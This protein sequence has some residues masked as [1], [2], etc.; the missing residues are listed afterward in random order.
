[1]RSRPR[2]LRG[3]RPILRSRRAHSTPRSL[4]IGLL[5]VLLGAQPAS[6]QDSGFSTAR[7]D[8]LAAV[9]AAAPHG[10]DD[11]TAASRTL[12]ALIEGGVGSEALAH[13]KVYLEADVDSDLEGQSRRDALASAHQA[14]ARQGDTLRPARIEEVLNAYFVLQLWS[15]DHDTAIVEEELPQVQLVGAGSPNRE[16]VQDTM[17]GTPDREATSAAFDNLLARW[18]AADVGSAE[19]QRAGQA[20]RDLVRTTVGTRALDAFAEYLEA[21][22]GTPAESDARA[23]A[24]AAIPASLTPRRAVELMSAYHFVGLFSEMVE[25]PLLPQTSMPARPVRPGGAAAG[26]TVD[27]IRRAGLLPP[28]SWNRA[29]PAPTVSQVA[30]PDP[31]SGLVVFRLARGQRVRTSGSG[32]FRGRIVNNTGA[33]ILVRPDLAL[34]VPP[35]LGMRPYTIMVEGSL[36]TREEE[37]ECGVTQAGPVK[38]IPVPAGGSVP[39]E[40]RLDPPD[41]AALGFAERWGHL[42]A[43]RDS[44]TAEMGYVS[45]GASGFTLLKEPT[46]IRDRTEAALQPDFFLHLLL[47]AVFGG[48]MVAMLQIMVQAPS[49]EQQDQASG[50]RHAL[51]AAGIALLTVGVVFTLNAAGQAVA[52][53]LQLKADAPLTALA[54]GVMIQAAGWAWWADWLSKGPPESGPAPEPG[55]TPQ[56]AGGD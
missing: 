20:L 25:E 36:Q 23:R 47:P 45:F 38:C 53:P 48:F 35:K 3:E 9:W 28:M 22:V 56:P 27:R 32:A 2:A 13:Y 5:S 31:A 55:P 41:S 12:R 1:M 29:R 44:V 33:K 50:F 39:V 30:P 17:W 7:F 54:A 4:A 10:S 8:S 24:L 19:E 40:F 37:K 11:E 52:F 18:E 14:L 49:T 15:A 46:R 16:V 6:A 26:P 43:P 34:W 21:D 51:W 42:H